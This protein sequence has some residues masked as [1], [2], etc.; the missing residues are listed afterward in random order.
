MHN[1]H[2]GCV[3]V[4]PN[5]AGCTEK[6][7]FLETLRIF[8]PLPRTKAPLPAPFPTQKHADNKND[9]DNNGKGGEENI[10]TQHWKVKKLRRMQQESTRHSNSTGIGNETDSSDIENSAMM[11]RTLHH[12]DDISYHTSDDDT[13]CGNN[14]ASVHAAI[15]VTYSADD[16]ISSDDSSI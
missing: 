1:A 11:N 7:D 13:T 12:S 8:K 16:D 14:G 15:D 10:P 6:L 5:H 3:C 2:G 9:E 4:Q